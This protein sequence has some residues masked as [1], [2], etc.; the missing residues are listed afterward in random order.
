MDLEVHVERYLVKR[1][2]A[3]GGME[4]KLEP[5]AQAHWPDR[6]VCLPGGRTIYAELKRPRDSRLREGQKEK[7]ARLAALGMEVATL[8]SKED[9][10]RIFRR[11]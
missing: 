10:D 11:P 8:W 3:A 7:L 9:V 6:L 4:R 5:G 1:V 2:K